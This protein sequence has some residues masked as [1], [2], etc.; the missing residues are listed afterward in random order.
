M[1]RVGT[2]DFDV[3]RGDSLK[4]IISFAEDGVPFDVSAWEFS[5]QVRSDPDAEDPPLAEFGFD[6]AG[7]ENGE[8]TASISADDMAT[9]GAVR[10][11]SYDLQ[12][13]TDAGDTV[14]FMRGRLNVIKDV[15][16]VP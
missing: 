16:R 15:T 2:T 6:L 3:V 1:S 10:F 12:A 9:L 8:V 14:T 5:G 11:Y 4:W 7:A 13:V